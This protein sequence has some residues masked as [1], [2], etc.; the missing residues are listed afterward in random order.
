[1]KKT[2][3]GMIWRVLGGIVLYLVLASATWLLADPGPASRFTRA[4][5]MDQAVQAD[6]GLIFDI[7]LDLP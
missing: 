7:E 4:Q 5:A 1:M 3:Q 2:D 6:F